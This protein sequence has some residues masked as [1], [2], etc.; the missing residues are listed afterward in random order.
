MGGAWLGLVGIGGP[1][2]PAIGRDWVPA[3]FGTERENAGEPG[4]LVPRGRMFGTNVVYGCVPS[5]PTCTGGCWLEDGCWWCRLDGCIEGEEVSEDGWEAEGLPWNSLATLKLSAVVEGVEV[6]NVA[7][8]DVLEEGADV[9][10]FVGGVDHVETRLEG[11]NDVNVVVVIGGRGCLDDTVDQRDFPFI[12]ESIGAVAG[13]DPNDLTLSYFTT[14]VAVSDDETGA[15]ASSIEPK[16]KE[17]PARGA[18]TW[19]VML[20]QCKR[21]YPVWQSPHYSVEH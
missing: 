9:D 18:D 14:G 11:V 15:G 5:C 21:S 12:R 7:D 2:G 1:P 4:P 8:K 16:F 19:E 17:N 20:V 3:P 6:D 10:E 13:R